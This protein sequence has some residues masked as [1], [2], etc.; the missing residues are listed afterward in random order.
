LVL[1]LLSWAVVILI[2]LGNRWFINRRPEVEGAAGTDEPHRVLVLANQTVE[3]QELLDE[4]RRIDA[5][6]S[7]TYFVVVPASPIEAG[8]ATN[9]PLD[10]LEATRR[11]AQERLDGTLST[12]HSENLEA[13]GEIGDTR[14]LRAL[15]SAVASFHPDQIVISTLP[16]ESSVWHRF[17]VVDRAR[18]E[19]DVPVTH[20]VA[21]PARA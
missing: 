14:P 2:Y 11:V 21:A 4:L 20:V 19:Y 15:A 18:A 10:L 5:T 1:S 8:T 17:D 12:L 13:E 16:P 3:S 9:G 7:A 6:R